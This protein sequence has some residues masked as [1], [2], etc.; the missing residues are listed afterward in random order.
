MA[1]NW[2]KDKIRQQMARERVAAIDERNYNLPPITKLVEIK[3][4]Q[5]FW[6]QWRADKQQMKALGYR[7]EKT[8]TGQWKVF[9]SHGA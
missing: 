1:L 2:H 4:D 3:P 5:N 8:T 6:K 7:V 9:K